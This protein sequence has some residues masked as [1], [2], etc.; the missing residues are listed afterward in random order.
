MKRSSAPP[1]R[2]V[3]RAA[4]A[5]GVLRLVDEIVCINPVRFRTY[6]AFAVRM[7][8]IDAARNARTAADDALLRARF[9]ETAETA[10]ARDG[11]FHVDQPARL[12]ILRAAAH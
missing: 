3:R 2:R 9:A 7:G 8:V 1:R 11:A 5:D 10:E 12:F 4:P 6:D